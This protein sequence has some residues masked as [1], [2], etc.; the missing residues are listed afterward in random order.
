MHIYNISMSFTLEFILGGTHIEESSW[1]LYQKWCK[2]PERIR[3][4][5][6]AA[7]QTV[8]N[9]STFGYAKPVDTV[10]KVKMFI[11][12]ILYWFI[13]ILKKFKTQQLKETFYILLNIC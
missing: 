4:A 8:M 12:L 3:N 10:I 7:G 13:N 2:M 9:F 11:I 6:V 1:K 5:W